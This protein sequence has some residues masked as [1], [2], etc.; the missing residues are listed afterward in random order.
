M[1]ALRDVVV[2]CRDPAPLARWWAGTLDGYRVAPYDEAELARLR[3]AGVEDP[4]DDPTVLVE[5]E[6]PGAGPRIWFQRVPEPKTVKNRVHLDL[7]V[8][9]LAA[10]VAGLVAR[11]A[12]VVADHD[13]WVVLADPEGDEFCVFPA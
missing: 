7:T 3:A 4:E 13:A 6:Q 5:P 11:G 9:E 10:G 12:T 2:D 1:A 8:P